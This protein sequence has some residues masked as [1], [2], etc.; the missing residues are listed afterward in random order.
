MLNNDSKRKKKVEQVGFSVRRVDD[1][2]DEDRVNHKKKKK[3]KKG[4]KQGKRLGRMLDEA[5]GKMDDYEEYRRAM[6]DDYDD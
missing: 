2:S 1:E 3:N 5:Y 4:H 6:M